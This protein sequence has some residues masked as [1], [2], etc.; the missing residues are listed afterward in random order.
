M[1]ARLPGA[2]TIVAVSLGMGVA[3]APAQ[4]VYWTDTVTGK[5]QRANIDGSGV[6]DLITLQQ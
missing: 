1:S 3:R 5:I 6:E 2:L 4:K